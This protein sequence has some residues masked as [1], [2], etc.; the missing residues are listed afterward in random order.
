MY[1]LVEME[2]GTFLATHICVEL[3][4][5]DAPCMQELIEPCEYNYVCMIYIVYL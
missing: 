4:T 5:P 3:R 2:N 1:E